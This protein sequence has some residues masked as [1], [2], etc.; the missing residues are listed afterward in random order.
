MPKP[1]PSGKVDLGNIYHTMR[2]YQK[3][4]ITRELAVKEL[5]TVSPI[6]LL[7][8][9]QN[10]L[11]KGFSKKDLRH[12]S[13]IYADIFR[14]RSRKTI[15]D[16]EEGHP[17]RTLLV[18]HAFIKSLLNEIAEFRDI[19]ADPEKELDPHIFKLLMKNFEET[20]KHFLKEEDVLLPKLKENGLS[21]RVE[22]IS[23]EHDSFIKHSI[24]LGD[25]ARHMDINREKIVEELDY[26]LPHIHLHAFTEGAILY[27]VALNVIDDWEILK[28]KMDI[29]GDPEF[30]PVGNFKPMKKKGD[31]KLTNTLEYMEEVES[32]S[33]GFILGDE[34]DEN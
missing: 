3:G 2:S 15:S 32:V 26:L 21:G 29:I 12:I 19:M 4:D 14:D 16:L 23:E 33:S 8:A 27:P 28:T 31:D 25:L 7:K 30:V 5:R 20:E 34:E 11:E 17:V 6:A 1:Y 22:M 18:E 13:E 10:L 9:E 24:R